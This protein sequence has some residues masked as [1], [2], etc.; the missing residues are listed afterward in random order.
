M[1][2]STYDAPGK[3]LGVQLQTTALGC[4]NANHC[5]LWVC[6]RDGGRESPA[7]LLDYSM[8]RDLSTRHRLGFIHLLSL[9][10]LWLWQ[11]SAKMW[12]CAVFAEGCG[13]AGVYG[14]ENALEH[15]QSPDFSSAHKQPFTTWGTGHE[16]SLCPALSSTAHGLTDT[17]SLLWFNASPQSEPLGRNPKAAVCLIR[18][19]SKIP[20]LPDLLPTTHP[21]TG[22]TH[23]DSSPQPNFL[24]KVLQL[25]QAH[26]YLLI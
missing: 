1:F 8:D 25:L 21:A 19:C 13:A 20:R 18:L 6:S 14:A 23:D 16:A 5:R 11:Q 9:R 15:P 4:T 12:P 3:R 26:T 7:L 17:L 2:N 22:L 10:V 24:A